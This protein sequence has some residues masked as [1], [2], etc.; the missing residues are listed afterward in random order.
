MRENV[1]KINDYTI[2][3]QL[4]AHPETIDG[5]QDGLAVRG[6]ITRTFNFLSAQ[7][8]TV[9]RDLTYETRGG[10]AGG[11][12]SVSTQTIIQ[13]FSDIQSDAEIR[14]M[15]QKLRDAG[16]KPPAIDDVLRGYGK[17]SAGLSA[18]KG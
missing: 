1:F 18:A 3:Q 10:S 16:G 13:N 14:L 15:H 9:T 8:T 5:Y 6:R 7:V 4:E 12:S 2:A 11:S 17:K